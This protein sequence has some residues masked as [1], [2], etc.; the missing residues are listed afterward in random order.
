METLKISIYNKYLDELGVE[1]EDQYT[2]FN[3]NRKDLLGYWIVR[4]DDGKYLEEGTPIEIM[5]YLSGHKFITPYKKSTINL[6]NDI[7]TENQIFYENSKS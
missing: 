3:F 1:Q 4:E 6:F 7:L 2:D 5:F